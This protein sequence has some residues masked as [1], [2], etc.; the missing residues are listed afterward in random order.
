MKSIEYFVENLKCAGCA[1]SVQSL[2]SQVPGINSVE[3]DLANHSARI[4]YD[5]PELA[6]QDLQKALADTSFVIRAK[7][8]G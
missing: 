5:G 4:Q 2:L 8:E 7:E 1:R 3:V 6:V